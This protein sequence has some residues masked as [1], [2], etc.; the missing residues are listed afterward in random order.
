M[1]SKA[2]RKIVYPVALLLSTGERKSFESLGRNI[3]ISGDSVTRL[4][5]HHAATKEELLK[6]VKQVFKKKKVK[7][8][9][10]DTLIN[11]I[12]SKKIN[13][14]CDNYDT[15]DKKVR[16]SI[17]AVVAVITDGK[18]AIPVDERIWISKEFNNFDYKKKW[19]LAKEIILWLQNEL[20]IGVVL[21]DGL[22]AVAEFMLWI[23]KQ[24]LPFEMRFHSNRVINHKGVSA[25]IKLHPSFKVNGKRPHRTVRATW[26]NHDFYFTALQRISLSGERSVVY[27]I[28]N[29]KAFSREHVRFYE[30]RWTIEIFF[31]TS[32]QK[33][34]LNDCLSQKLVLQENH[35][36]NVFFA[37]ALLQIERRRSRAPNIETVLKQLKR[38]DFNCL[39]TRFMRSAENFGLA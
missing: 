32:K 3:G 34:G 30:I 12:Y 24:G 5:E 10:D 7:L 28:S 23:D 22:Y 37:Y 6:I 15:S 2:E 29:Y 39:I 26:K 14:A 21:A 33:L 35:I 1:I 4:V 16:R 27:Q 17:C 20:S 25:Q 9:I 18:I 11:K 38:F 19:E 13:G 8:I 31:R 36:F